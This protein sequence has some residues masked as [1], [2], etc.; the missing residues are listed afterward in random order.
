MEQRCYE[1]N[2]AIAIDVIGF[3]APLTTSL[4]NMFLNA[5]YQLRV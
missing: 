4:P 2:E 1:F 3:P 5:M